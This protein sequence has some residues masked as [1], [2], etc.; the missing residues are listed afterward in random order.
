MILETG[1]FYLWRRV[2]GGRSRLFIEKSY[3][4]VARLR[5]PVSPWLPWLS[6]L[7]RL[8]HG[9]DSG[10]FSVYRRAQCA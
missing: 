9:D 4:T 10:S 3:R 5:S 2:I 8:N 6:I 1:R 7:Y